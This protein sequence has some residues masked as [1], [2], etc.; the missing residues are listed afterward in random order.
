MKVS[1]YI[2]K[3]INEK[4]G[5]NH[6]FMLS[7]GGWMHMLNSLGHNKNIKYICNLHEQAASIAAEAYGQYTN[8]IGVAMV[9]TGPGGTNAI[10]GVTAG[11]IDSTPMMIISG[12]VKRSDMIGNSDLRQRGPQEI[13]IIP[14]VTPITKYAV[15]VLDPL[16]IR[17]HLEKAYHL[18]T[19]GKKGP[20]WLDIPLD[21]QGAE[22]DENNLEGYIPESHNK[23][24]ILIDE[25]IDLINKSSRPVFFAGNGIYLAGAKEKFIEL[26]GK[27]NIPVLTTWKTIDFFDENDELYIGRPGS[28]AS[29]GA[30]F[31]LQNCDL[32]ISVGARMDFP[33]IAFN[34]KNFAR[35]AKKIIVD[36]DKSELEKFEGEN[37]KKINADAKDFIENLSNAAD[38]ITYKDNGWI[39][40]CKE[41]KNKYPLVQP[42]YLEL[43]KFVNSYVLVEA[44][45]NELSASDLI[46]PGS[47]GSCSEISCQ[48]FKIK[49][50]QIF[51]NNQGLGS[52]GFGLPASIGACIAS[53]QKRTICINGD[54]GFVMNIQ[55]LE[56]VKRLNLPIKYFILNNDG[57]GSIRNMQ[58][59]HFNGFYVG[60]GRTSGV[61]LPDFEK[62]AK[63]YGINYKKIDN[64]QNINEKVSDVLNT[65]GPVLC[66][67]LI[68][69]A[70]QTQPRVSSKK[71]DNGSMM[72]MPIENMWPFLDEDE[73]KNNLEN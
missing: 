26:A 42:E 29:R 32:F 2:I 48:A 70:M 57:Y 36:I 54:G 23:T 73:I 1:D 53:G 24:N 44:L 10:T 27:L 40:K 4:M 19:T 20:V 17:Y 31:N 60:S 63:S 12:Q 39:K 38:R 65:D 55:E 68:D 61:T 18:A 45:S 22:I 5:V 49:K 59:N 15:S 71:L 28:I 8:N 35:N 9:T 16:K 33:Q 30:N 62:I 52:M 50:G 37:I 13:N 69:P 6:V 14:I 67:V 11:W 25:I 43:K 34:F 51:L 66:E 7:G 58:N 56:T 47:S 72:S 64:Q 41:L 46:V 21:V 3:F